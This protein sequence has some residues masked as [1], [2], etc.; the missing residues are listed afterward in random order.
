M[1][2][3][4]YGKRHHGG[5]EAHRVRRALMVGDFEAAGMPIFDGVGT[6]A[7]R[8]AKARRVVAEYIRK[9][10]GLETSINT[11]EVPLSDLSKEVKAQVVNGERVVQDAIPYACAAEFVHQTVVV[12][13]QPE[14]QSAQAARA[15]MPA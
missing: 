13:P 2:D 15:H 6:R 8:R 10:G 11:E 3:H 12:I 4:H 14:E 7:G 1:N 9:N 5:F